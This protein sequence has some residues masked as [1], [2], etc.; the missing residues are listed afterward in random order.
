MSMYLRKAHVRRPSWRR[1]K[2]NGWLV[3]RRV[4]WLTLIIEIIV[5][6]LYSPA[7]MVRRVVVEGTSLTRSDEVVRTARIVDGSQWLLLPVSRITKRLEALPTVSEA[8]VARGMPNTV[9]I[10][11]LERR[12][13]ALLRTQWNSYWIDENGVLFWKSSQAQGLPVIQW[14][15]RTPVVLGQAVQNRS[16]R[17]ALEILYRY[18]PRYQL[19]VEQITV[20]LEGDICLNMR[21]GLLVKMGDSADLQ[22]KV[23]LIS[24]LRQTTR[25]IQNTVYVDVS[26]VE[27]PVWKP[28]DNQK[29]AL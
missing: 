16:V 14:Q 1:R 2:H 15:A 21:D 3:A 5:A 20:D 9:H 6:L 7:L 17:T 18:V 24:S 8:V 29:G 26:C 23:V 12:P 19:P 13:L 10:R 11:V 28:R 27:K 4:L 25:I 22:Q